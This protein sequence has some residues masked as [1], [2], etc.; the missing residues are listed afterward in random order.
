MLNNKTVLVPQQNT[1]EQTVG[2]MEM[3]EEM[4]LKNRLNLTFVRLFI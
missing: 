3:H 1:A 2:W 4:K